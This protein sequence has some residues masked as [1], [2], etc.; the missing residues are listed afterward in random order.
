MHSNGM[1]NALVVDPEGREG[2]PLQVLLQ[3]INLMQL[4]LPMIQIIL[5]AH[6]ILVR[7]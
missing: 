5:Y 6:G 1:D 3:K 2:L 7:L 4:S